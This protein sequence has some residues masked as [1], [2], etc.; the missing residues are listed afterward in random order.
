VHLSCFA[1]LGTSVSPSDELIEQLSNYVCHLYGYEHQ[2]DVNL[3]RYL[4]FK[5][6][7]YEEEMLPPNEDSLLLHI[8]RAVY[9]C[10]IWRNATQPIL[11]LP[12]FTEHGWSIDESGMVCVKWMSLPPAP[13]SVLVLVNC[14]CTKGCENNRC[15]CK[16]SGLQCTDVCKCCDC[17]N[18]KADSDYP[19]DSDNDVFDCSDCSSDSEQ[20]SD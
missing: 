5:A 15:S 19:D 17:K 2:S 6:G 18:G 14:K 13:D 1:N 12:N 10:Y 16:K 7:K 9:Q 3:V 11:N 20:E 4:A 8:Y